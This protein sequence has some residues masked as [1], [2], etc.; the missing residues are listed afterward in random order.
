MANTLILN[1]FPLKIAPKVRRIYFYNPAADPEIFASNLTRINHIRFQSSKDLVWLEI[2]EVN[3]KLVPPEVYKYKLDREDSIDNDERAFFKTFYS[4]V[5]KL[6][7]DN[8]YTKLQRRRE[9]VKLAPLFK[10][11]SNEG[12]SCYVSYRVQLYNIEGNHYVSINP[13]FLFLSSDPVLNSPINGSYVVNIETGKSYPLVGVE[14]GKLRILV[15]GKEVEVKMPENYY[16][17]FSTIEAERLCFVKEVHHIY[18]QKIREFYQRIPTDLNFLHEVVD[19]SKPLEV[20]NEKVLISSNEFQFHGGTSNKVSEIFKLGPLMNKEES[21]KLALFFSSKNQIVELIPTLKVIFAK[22]QLLAKALNSL[23]FKKLELVENPNT[24][25][26]YFLYDPETLK[27]LDT[28]ALRKVKGRTYA[29][30]VLDKFY[31]NL[32]PLIASF[33]QNFVLLPILKENLVNKQVYVMNSFAY[34]VLNFTENALPYSVDIPSNTL[35]I[36]VDLSHDHISKKSHFAISAV[37]YLGKVIYVGAKRNLQLNERFSEEIITEYFQRIFER[38][39]ER[40]GESPA[41]VIIIRDGSWLEDIERIVEDLK[42]F[43][44]E[45]ALVEIVKNSAINSPTSLQEHVIKITNEMCVYFPK[46][47]HNQKGV[48]IRIRVNNTDMGN[49]E[50]MK[51]VY[52]ATILYHPTPYTTLSIPYPIYITDKIALLGGEWKFYIPYFF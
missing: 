8:G 33:P 46:T 4:Y 23:N 15:N 3:L 18:K 22:E 38:Y 36:G 43:K 41:R 24:H 25:Q 52:K 27:P 5:T 39:K 44:G 16:F 13:K 35:F 10:L 45:I 7:K 11:S 34:K 26:P 51:A 20:S 21:L 37:D 49:E 42:R 47:Y 17:N 12:V 14:D 1:L 9:Y 48:E 2:P 30:I 19:F 31:G 28:D 29:I 32:V 40:Y 50:I 6:F